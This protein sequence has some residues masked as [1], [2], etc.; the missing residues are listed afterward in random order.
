M[1][2]IVKISTRTY[3]GLDLPPAST[4]L[5]APTWIVGAGGLVEKTEPLGLDASTGGEVIAKGNY[6]TVLAAV[7]TRAKQ[8]GQLIPYHESNA[9]ALIAESVDLHMGR[10]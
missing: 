10:K 1:L 3:M 9:A 6:S 8:K 5:G 7:V 4:Y 2:A